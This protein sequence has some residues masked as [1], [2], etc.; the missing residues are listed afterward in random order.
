MMSCTLAP[1]GA[2]LQLNCSRSIRAFQL[3]MGSSYYQDGNHNDHLSV[4]WDANTMD[5]INFSLQEEYDTN[6]NFNASVAGSELTTSDATGTPRIAIDKK[7]LV[8]FEWAWQ[9]ALLKANSGQAFSV[10][11]A[12]FMQYDPKTNTSAPVQKMEVLKVYDDEIM[13]LPKGDVTVRKLT[14]GSFSAW[15]AKED[16]VAGIPRP[17]KFDDGMFV[18]TITN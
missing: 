15:Y 2:N 6:V 18:Y 8:E 5:L 10:P 12:F 17:V 9:V 16:A 11:F 1:A 7:S 14:L 13:K 3:Q 4:T